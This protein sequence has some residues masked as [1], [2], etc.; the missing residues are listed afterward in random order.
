MSDSVD[1]RR[2]HDIYR[3]RDL[4]GRLL[5]VGVTNGGLRRFMEHAKDKTWWREVATID[6]EHV[7]CTRPVIEA[8]EREAIQ[9]ERPLYNVT[10]NVSRAELP[11]PPPVNPPT[12]TEVAE[13]VRKL[14]VLGVPDSA[15]R[16]Q[17]IVSLRSAGLS[18]RY[19]VIVGAQSY[20]HRR[21]QQYAPTGRAAL[22]GR[23]RRNTPATLKVGDTVEHP[24]FGAGG[25]QQL[26]GSGEKEEAVIHF[27]QYGIKHL[28][29]AWA[30]LKKVDPFGFLTPDGGEG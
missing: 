12:V 29:T 8:M 10:H 28:A 15:S 24:V 27:A 13:L 16:R 14:D 30:P 20:R 5:Y 18:A 22:G 1:E 25:V 19:S 17:I 11:P 23:A 6:I 3:M 21:A 9:L 4:S 26:T 2:L 7:H